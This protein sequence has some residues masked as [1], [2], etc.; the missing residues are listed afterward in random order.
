MLENTSC[1]GKRREMASSPTVQFQLINRTWRG[2]STSLKSTLLTPLV[3]V[4]TQ[5][6]RIVGCVLCVPR[7]V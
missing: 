7:C 5:A 2:V 4:G 3:H 6:S 1:K